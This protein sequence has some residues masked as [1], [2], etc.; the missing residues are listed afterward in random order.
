M[1]KIKLIL[2]TLVATLLVFTGVKIANA[3]GIG[4]PLDNFTTVPVIKVKDINQPLE[5]NVDSDSLI[6]RYEAHPTNPNF[7]WNDRPISEAPPALTPLFAQGGAVKLVPGDKVTYI[8]KFNQKVTFTAKSLV[9][10]FKVTADQN[11]T[12]IFLIG[13]QRPSNPP[14]EFDIEIEGETKPTY[15]AFTDIDYS[16]SVAVKISNIAQIVVRDNTRIT[17]HS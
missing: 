14:A 4:D 17:L 16:D 6:F 1:Q 11:P 3:E 15:V 2:A 10:D 7:L 5:V 13:N 8:N 12:S 9:H